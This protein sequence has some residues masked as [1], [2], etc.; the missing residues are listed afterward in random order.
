MPDGRREGQ[1]FI[2][3]K[4]RSGVDEQTRESAKSAERGG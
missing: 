2:G 3:R 4:G 1:P